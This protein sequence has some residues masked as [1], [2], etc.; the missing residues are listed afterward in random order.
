MVPRVSGRSAFPWSAAVRDDKAKEYLE[1]FDAIRRVI[2][3]GDAGPAIGIVAHTRKP[4]VGERA[5]GRARFEPWTL[6][7]PIASR[8]T[9][10]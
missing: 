4:H 5:S 10:S 7:F 8:E 3:A 1:T 9:R 2:P 6:K